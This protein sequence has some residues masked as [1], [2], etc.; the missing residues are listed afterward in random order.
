MDTDR[1]GIGDGKDLDDDGD[2]MPDEW[3]EMHDLDPMDPGDASLDAD[4][5]G[6]TNL[7]EYNER[8]DPNKGKDEEQDFLLYYIIVMIVGVVIILALVIYAIVL[9]KNIREGKEERNFFREE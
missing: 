5:D 1:D 2:G 3:E 4:E 8:T 6:K 7:E 9:R